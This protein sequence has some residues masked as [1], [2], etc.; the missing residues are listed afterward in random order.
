M[1]VQPNITES[2]YSVPF[3]RH[4]LFGLQLGKLPSAEQSC[5]D[6]SGAKRYAA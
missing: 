3:L 4:R 2:A 5:R 6:P 1:V